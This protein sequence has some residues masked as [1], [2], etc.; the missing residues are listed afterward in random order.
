MIE[1]VRVICRKTFFVN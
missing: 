1:H